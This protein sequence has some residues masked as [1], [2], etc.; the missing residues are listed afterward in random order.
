MGLAITKRLIEQQS[1][2]IRVTSELGK[3]SCFN[4]TLPA[5]RAVPEV[6][7]QTT[8]D[9][10][11]VNAAP[12]ASEKPLILVVDDEAS[13][14][15]LLTSYLESAGYGVAVA[16][17]STEAIRKATQSRPSAITL[18]I[19][20]PGGSGFETLYQLKNTPKTGNIP[21]IVVSVVDQKQLGFT[22]GAAE[23]L[24]KP[25]QRSV[26]LDTIRKYTG[27]PTETSSEILVV[28]DDEKTR[29]LVADILRSQGYGA[30]LAGSGQEALQI[31]AEVPV[32]AVL[33]DLIMPEMDGFDVLRRIKDNLKLSD[34]PVFVVT[35]KD[36]TD[37]ELK[38]LKREARALLRKDQ[39]WKTELLLQLRKVLTKSKLAKSVGQA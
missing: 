4:F 24:V 33:L 5:G 2:T 1:G 16:N 15:E 29:D 12:D 28:D 32:I 20:M 34:I 13:A 39:S 8:T 7:L 35:A 11:P 14:R 37:E 31:L 19:L 10:V 38:L 3:G 30:R 27:L 36:L 6:A 23:Y 18:D 17:S 26:L 22:L 21:I 9:E 25:V